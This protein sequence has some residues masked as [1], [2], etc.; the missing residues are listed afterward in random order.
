MAHNI[1]YNELNFA[2]PIRIINYDSKFA[3]IQWLLAHSQIAGGLIKFL[4]FDK[5]D[6]EMTALAIAVPTIGTV[7]RYLQSFRKVLYYV[8][9]MGRFTAE[10]VGNINDAVVAWSDQAVAVLTS[11]H[12][13]GVPPPN[14]SNY[15]LLAHWAK[16]SFDT[17]KFLLN[18]TKD[19][20]TLIDSGPQLQS[21][22]ENK[23]PR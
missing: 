6:V 8:A 12:P 16:L 4:Y 9:E 21:L 7:T 2:N 20:C 5:S 1:N 19:A 14:S 15:W 13:G 18:K 3:I 11:Y 17:I 23:E 22:S 10:E